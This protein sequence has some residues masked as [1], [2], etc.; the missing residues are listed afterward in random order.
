MPSPPVVS[1]VARY[2][3]NLGS[4]ADETIATLSS[5]RTTIHP[6]RSSL[7][8]LRFFNR[9]CLFAGALVALPGV[10]YAQDRTTELALSLLPREARS[11]ASVVIRNGEDE[12]MVRS[13]SGPFLCVVDVNNAARLSLNCHDRKLIPLLRLEREV[14]AAGLRG[15]AFREELCTRVEAEA[16]DQPTGLL[17][18]SASVG[19]SSE[20]QLADS[21]TVYHLLYMP[22]ETSASLGLRDDGPGAGAPWLHN[23]GSCNAHV[24]WSERRPTVGGSL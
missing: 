23:A 6:A 5:W 10:V 13:G 18:I 7:H 19:I 17:E 4:G 24:M 20:G 8:E 14:G 15:A 16:A 3:H 12:T 2:Q 11:G 21:M 1:T 22:N 9:V